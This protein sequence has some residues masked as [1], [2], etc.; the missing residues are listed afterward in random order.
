MMGLAKVLSNALVKWLRL[1][2]PILLIRGLQ[3]LMLYPYSIPG[4]L[5]G[6]QVTTGPSRPTPH[7]LAAGA[8]PGG[9]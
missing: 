7:D 4:V 1:P 9:I 8:P 6:S 2:G 3:A 5:L